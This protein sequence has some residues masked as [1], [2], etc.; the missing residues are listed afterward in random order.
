V[1]AEIAGRKG[2]S[3]A[4]VALRWAIQRG[5]VPIPRSSHPQRVAANLDIFDFALDDAD[6]ARIEALQ[7]PASRIANPV[8]RAPAWD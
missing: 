4:Q 8:G 6:M 1:L 2:K 5:A 3:S 7:R